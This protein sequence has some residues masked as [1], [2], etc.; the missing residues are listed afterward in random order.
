MKYNLQ[1]LTTNGKLL[2]HMKGMVNILKNRW[3]V[4][5][6]SKLKEHVKKTK[7]YIPLCCYRFL[8][9]L[10]NILMLGIEFTAEI[11]YY[12]ME[13]S[14]KNPAEEHSVLLVYETLKCARDALSPKISP[15][16]FLQYIKER[17]YAECPKL[18]EQIRINKDK[19]SRMSKV[20][21]AKSVTTTVSVG[22]PIAVGGGSTRNSSPYTPFAPSML[23]TRANTDNDIDINDVE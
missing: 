10:K 7:Q 9:V 1:C 18:L 23:G 19:R 14:L 17:N 20:Q 6:V 3:V 22:S 12:V 2:I 21:M 4:Q 8:S 15:E 5:A 13:K 16:V 11:Y